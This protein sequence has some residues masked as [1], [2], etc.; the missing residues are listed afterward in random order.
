MDIPI[1][2]PAHTDSDR[3]I[4]SCSRIGLWIEKQLD[5]TLTILYCGRIGLWILIE[6]A[7]ML[8][9]CNGDNFIAHVNFPKC[10]HAIKLHVA[11]EFSLFNIRYKLYKAMK[12][13]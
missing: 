11:L 10:Y 13:S 2:T 12:P 8:V 3:V 9:C 4:L 7:K 5:L 6:L 1:E